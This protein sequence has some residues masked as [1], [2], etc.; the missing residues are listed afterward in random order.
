MR[1]HYHVTR[2]YPDFTLEL[3]RSI[4]KQ[5]GRW[6]I[7][8]KLEEPIR[9]PSLTQKKTSS[10]LALLNLRN[11]LGQGCEICGAGTSLVAA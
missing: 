9:T 3:A 10:R 11:P 6:V 2:T 4:V 5:D 8:T 1:L 7:A